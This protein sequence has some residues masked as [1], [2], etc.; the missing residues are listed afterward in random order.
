MIVLVAITPQR[1]APSGQ[2]AP[3]Y[4][5]HRLS[6]WALGSRR[7][8]A[9]LLHP[10]Q[11]SSRVPAPAPRSLQVLAARRKVDRLK[12]DRLPWARC[13]VL[14][15]LR[16]RPPAWGMSRR[17]IDE[18]DLESGLRLPRGTVVAASQWVIH[19]DA[20][21]FADPLSFRPERWTDGLLD[22]LPA[23]THFPFGAGPRMCVGRHF[24]LQ[25]LVLILASLAR[26]FRLNLMA[27]VDPAP[28]LSITM[29]PNG[30]IP[31]QLES[32]DRR[33]RWYRAQT[34]A[35]MAER[36]DAMRCAWRGSSDE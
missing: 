25:E 16:L 8:A 1:A 18:T 26:R 9:M 2:R 24:A 7:A 11:P 10:S 31:V 12:P 4:Q 15:S 3:Q 20:R 27:P 19:R 34:P 29:H 32:V 33:V 13:V 17:F 14:E 6:T 36:F 21:F 28:R 22:R 30:P 23:G 35:T 5:G